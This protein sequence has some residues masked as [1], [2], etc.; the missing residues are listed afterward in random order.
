MDGK[1]AGRIIRHESA[2]A[3]RLRLAKSDVSDQFH[4][5]SIFSRSKES[6][7]FGLYLA[8]FASD[9]I[10]FALAFLAAGAMR[11]GSPFETQSV[12]T[13]ALLLPTFLAVALNNQSYSISALQ[14]PSIGVTRAVKALVYAVA[15]AIAF[16]FYVKASINF[17]RQIFAVGTVLSLFSVAA[18]RAIVGERIGRYYDWNF[19][20]RLLILDGAVTRPRRGEVAIRAEVFGIELSDNDPHLLARLGHLLTH[21]DEVV[22]SCGVAKRAR[23]TQALKGS[24]LHVEI[25]TPELTPFGA[26]AMGDFDGQSTLQVCSK[27]LNQRDRIVKRSLDL[28][29]AIPALVI[30]AP[31]LV[32]TAIAI[33][34]ESRGPVLFRQ[35]R[36]G[37]NNNMF[38]LLKFR[39][40]KDGQCDRDGDRSTARD[41]VRTTRVGKFIRATSIDELPQ[42]FN[43]IRGQMSIVGPR[44]HALGS[45]AEKMLFWHIDN[46]YFHRHAVKPGMTGLAQIRGFRGATEMRDDLTNRLHADLEYLSGWTVWR[47][48]KIIALTF[49]VVIHPNAF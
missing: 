19:V 36:V 6:L 7:R 2:R 38:E 42:L 8:L 33:R 25:L 10:A 28:A 46:R 14:H 12:M 31:L 35:T 45:T 34:A 22:V 15:V 17:S 41:D 27:P 24:A 48:I 40:M 20:N 18:M 32:L 43:V 4:G 13:L 47:D 49:A 39:S 21:C 29:I 9:L 11:L 3:V 37:Q 30:L 44:P 26:I 23:W 16:L 5:Q 1:I